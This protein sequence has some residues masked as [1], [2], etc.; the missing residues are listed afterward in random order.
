MKTLENLR[1]EIDEIDKGLVELFMRRMKAA[2]N[3]AEIKKATSS[4]VYDPT[5]ERKILSTVADSV[6]G[7]LENEARLL[8]T[9]LFS[10]S[11]GL[12]R[13]TLAKQSDF[14][15]SLEKALKESPSA[16]PSRASVA[17]PGAEG[18]YSQQ[19]ASQLVKFPT[20]FYFKGFEDVF[21]A[22]EKGMCDYGILPIENSAVGSVSAVYDM[23]DRH[24]F[25]IVRAKRLRIRHVLLAKSGAKIENIKKIYSHPHALSQ[26][27]SFISSQKD[28]HAIPSTN[29]AVAARELASSNETDAAVIASRECA[30]LYNLDIIR[31]DIADVSTNYTRFICISKKDEIYADSTKFSVMMSLPHR[32][33]ALSDVLVKFSSCAVNLTKLE[34]R[35]IPGSDFEFRF[36]FDFE[37]SPHDPR[38][39][40]LLAGFECDPEIEHF[41][42]LGA[43]NEK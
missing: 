5:R 8:F 17:C 4:P 9:T 25:K 1:S 14:T 24:N 38:I 20:I 43:Y 33:G 34:S 19:A 2:S 21:N 39:I 32:A 35:P 15:V 10:I 18:S 12:Q 31:E 37:A 41:T 16:F 42:F 26:C 23:M 6:G 36:I 40:K 28:I 27:S 29:T 30:Q 3:V 13:A 7:E 22:V 11:R